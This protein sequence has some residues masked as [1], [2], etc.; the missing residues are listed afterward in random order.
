MMHRLDIDERDENYIVTFEM[1]GI[2]E[3]DIIIEAKDSELH[4]MAYSKSIDVNMKENSID[5]DYKSKIFDKTA[6]LENPDFSKMKHIFFL[7]WLEVIV[8]KKVN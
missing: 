7:G 4:V 8:P 3:N 6:I 5:A 2:Q 1:P